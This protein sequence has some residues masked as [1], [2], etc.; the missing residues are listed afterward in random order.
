[1][2]KR[3]PD[4]TGDI[5]VNSTGPIVFTFSLSFRFTEKRGFLAPSVRAAYHRRISIDGEVPGT[6]VENKRA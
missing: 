4:K 3:R 5:R 6:D 1:M 2:H